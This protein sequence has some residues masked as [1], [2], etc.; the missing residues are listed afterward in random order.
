MLMFAFDGWKETSL[1]LVELNDHYLL[2]QYLVWKRSRRYNL[3]IW[4]Y[5]S[6]LYWEVC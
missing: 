1:K 4:Y 2:Q 5:S 3:W 6:E